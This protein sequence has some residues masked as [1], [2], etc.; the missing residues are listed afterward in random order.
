MIIIKMPC[1][2]KLETRLWA[3]SRT[4]YPIVSMG[5]PPYATDSRTSLPK[6]HQAM[7]QAYRA[8]WE[9]YHRPEIDRETMEQALRALA[10]SVE[11]K[12]HRNKEDRC[13]STLSVPRRWIMI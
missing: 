7:V 11:P 1:L 10:D 5:W 13:R 8:E 4:G 12:W 9:S 3:S 2:L 6:R